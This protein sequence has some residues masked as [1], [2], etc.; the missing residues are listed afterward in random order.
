M[1]SSR[2][3]LLLV[4]GS[5]LLITQACTHPC[6]ATTSRNSA[7]SCIQNNRIKRLD[8]L[9]L[10]LVYDPSNLAG[11]T[12]QGY[13][14][15]RP[16]KSAEDLLLYASFSGEAKTA[17][18]LSEPVA[19][20]ASADD[21][22]YATE[23]APETAPVVPKPS[24]KRQLLQFPRARLFT[25]YETAGD[26]IMQETV[27]FVD[28]A[29]ALHSY[30]NSYSKTASGTAGPL[31]AIAARSM[32]LPVVLSALAGPGQLRPLQPTLRIVGGVEAPT[33]R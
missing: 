22:W 27:S 18:L 29:G 10:S 32:Q 21:E 12:V 17:H 30:S 19:V 24:R 13:V 23:A 26:K 20:E 31:S 6:A 5:L 2:A 3:A 15:Q 16:L 8:S 4:A 14:Q 9:L 33:D 7:L 11:S 1:Q 28:P 25:N